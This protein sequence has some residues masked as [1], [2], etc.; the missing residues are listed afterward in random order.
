[1][2]FW[3]DILA[4]SLARMSD[5][6]IDRFEYIITL[7]GQ[8]HQPSEEIDRGRA[9][10]RT[11]ISIASVSHFET[12]RIYFACR[13]AVPWMNHD[14]VNRTGQ[15]LL[16]SVYVCV[17]FVEQIGEQ[18]DRRTSKLTETFRPI[19]PI[20]EITSTRGISTFASARSNRV[21]LA[22]MHPWTRLCQRNHV[23][24]WVDHIRHDH[25]V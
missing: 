9:N 3:A 5:R 13:N 7:V 10:K 21:Y 18:V 11:E 23:E 25:V 22:C 1:M 8:W 17:C 2:I 12:W 14:C 20:N 19:K 4:C 24:F 15:N 6:S 16:D